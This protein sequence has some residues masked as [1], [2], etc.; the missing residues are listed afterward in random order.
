MDDR[1]S[2]TRAAIALS[3]LTLAALALSLFERSQAAREVRASSFETAATEAEASTPAPARAAEQARATEQPAAADTA[4]PDAALAHPHPITAEHLALYRDVDLLDAAWQAARDGDFAQAR[5]LLAEHRREYPRSDDDLNEGLSLL[6]DC[7]QEP[8]VA[9][10]ERA[11]RFYDTRT[12]SM[13]RRRIRRH[14]LEPLA[15]L[16]AA[17][18]RALDAR[19]ALR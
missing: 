3:A 2:L 15:A 17:P 14:C 10:R 8:S 9:A 5:T 7:M 13:M 16:D 19:A 12:F 1:R 4:P 18:P 6:V 11:Q